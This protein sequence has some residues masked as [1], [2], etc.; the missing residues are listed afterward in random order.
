MSWRR[1]RGRS[2]FRGRR[3]YNRLDYP[4][5]DARKHSSEVRIRLAEEDLGS[6]PL[7]D[8]PADA[9]G[10]GVGGLSVHG[11]RTGRYPVDPTVI[12]HTREGL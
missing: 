3:V 4:Q 12:V 6:V 10:A 1:R 8:D 5:T 7:P 11:E 2:G 9:R